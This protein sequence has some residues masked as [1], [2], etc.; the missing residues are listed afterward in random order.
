MA[1]LASLL[2]ALGIDSREYDKGLDDALD[3]TR[4]KGGMIGSIMG[5]IGSVAG[6]VL[7][8]GI[9][10]AGA[11]V[12][13]LGSGL[14]FA[15]KEAMDAEEITAQL[16]AVLK[17]TGGAAG[18]TADMAIDLAA[19][20]S[21]VTRFEDD[22]I[23]AGEN[24]LLTF[25]NIGKDVFPA[26][27]QT[28]L[29]MSTALGQDLNTS[30]MQ[31]GKALNDPIQGVTALRRVGVQ[32]TDDQS[33]LIKKLVETGDVAGAQRIILEELGRE[34]GN[35]A[36]AAGGTFAGQL[37]IL[38]NT[39]GNVAETVGTAFLPT[40]KELAGKLVEFVQSDQFQEWVQKISD[41]LM[42]ELPVAIQ[43]ASDFWSNTLHPA[44]LTIGAALGVV[45]QWLSENIPPA[46]AKLSEFWTTTLKPALETVWRFIIT[47][48]VPAFQAIWNFF[49]VTIPAA[50]GKMRAAWNSDFGGIRTIVEGMWK[51]VQLVFDLFKK[52]FEGDWRG[53]GETLRAI[54]DNAWATI[55]TLFSDGVDA[56][57]EFLR[58][59]G[60]RVREIDWLQLGKDI[61]L[62]I[63]A[64][65]QSAQQA[66]LDAMIGV[67]QA[68]VD[69]VKGFLGIESPSRLM[70]DQVGRMMALGVGEGWEA[71][72]PNLN[73]A[74]APA[75]AGVSAAGLGAVGRSGGGMVIAPVYNNYG[76]S[77]ADEQ[78]VQRILT[79]IVK[80]INAGR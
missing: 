63:A 64:G 45:W 56:V 43:K 12:I 29:D 55:K 60:P 57:L 26:T 31:L 9:A 62:G 23:L 70:A 72:L 36:Q 25:T 30:A 71:G 32:L 46:I 37:D 27:T 47:Y 17:S 58:N 61:I 66:V 35:S 39:L 5:G 76:I 41:W 15:I 79:P 3:K 52:T 51:H 65:I 77:L 48:I 13:G 19:G 50:L 40:I 33:A 44:L 22:A 54:V 42:N 8:A 16:Q 80:N 2:I 38:R 78:T 18:V 49:S 69:I 20:L 75:V 74:L 7:T 73:L 1:T 6:G 11:G 24:M 4:S 68:G 59:L 28:M 14:G 21:Q 10:T 67:I 53:V 34:F